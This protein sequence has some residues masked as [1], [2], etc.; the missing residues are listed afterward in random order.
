MTTQSKPRYAVFERL[1]N[2]DR[3]IGETDQ[4]N[5]AAGVADQCWLYQVWDRALRQ[6]VVLP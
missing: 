4:I 2:S 1:S 6:W 3:L 5:V